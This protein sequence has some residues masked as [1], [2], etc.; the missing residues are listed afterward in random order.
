MRHTEPLFYASYRHKGH[1]ITFSKG[2][3]KSLWCGVGASGL[4]QRQPKVTRAECKDSEWMES[5]RGGPE[6]LGSV[7]CVS[8]TSWG[9]GGTVMVQAGRARR[10]GP[11]AVK[12]AVTCSSREVRPPGVRQRLG[13]H[14]PAECEGSQNLKRSQEA[15]GSNS[16]PPCSGCGC[17]GMGRNL[18]WWEGTL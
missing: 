6:L 11:W 9:P 17:L 13:R 14:H 4:W 7:A 8:A 18:G 10:P 1:H 3:S 5:W 16:E 2:A 15:C 12:R